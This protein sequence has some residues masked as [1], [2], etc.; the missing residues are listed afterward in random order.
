MAQKSYLD[1][2]SEV[3]DTGRC[4]GCGACVAACPAQAATQYGFTNEQVLAEI[5]GILDSSTRSRFIAENALTS[6]E[7]A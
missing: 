1:L 5:D 4:S 7:M 2:K 3:W 6:R